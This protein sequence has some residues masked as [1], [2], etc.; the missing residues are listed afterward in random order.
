MVRFR[1]TP[2]LQLFHEEDDQHYAGHGRIAQPPASY[3]RFRHICRCRRDWPLLR[4]QVITF[5]KAVN[6]IEYCNYPLTQVNTPPE[7]LRQ[8]AQETSRMAGTHRHH[9][10]VQH[11]NRVR[12][13]HDPNCPGEFR[14][15]FSTIFAQ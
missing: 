3:R 9:L 11:S 13:Q 5:V 10:C 2:C 4:P 1:P 7:T 14:F 8:S 15:N 6:L 12:P